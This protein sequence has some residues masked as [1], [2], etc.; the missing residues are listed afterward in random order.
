MTTG[1]DDG[2]DSTAHHVSSIIVT[3]VGELIIDTCSAQDIES[4]HRL[5][6]P[7]KIRQHIY[8]FV[9]LS[10]GGSVRPP[11]KG[12]TDQNY[13]IELA[14]TDIDSAPAWRYEYTPSTE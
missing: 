5:D 14:N 9:F 10:H 2:E 7:S 1:N 6:L 11:Y 12:Q 4:F 13:R 3:T 8:Y